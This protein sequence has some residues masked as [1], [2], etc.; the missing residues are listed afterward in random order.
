MKLIIGMHFLFSPLTLS[1]LCLFA[2]FFP[3]FCSFLALFC[4]FPFSNE[5]RQHNKQQMRRD[6][7]YFMCLR[8]I[9][10]NCSLFMWKIC[11]IWILHFLSWNSNQKYKNNVTELKSVSFIIINIYSFNCNDKQIEAFVIFFW[12]SYYDCVVFQSQMSIYILLTLTIWSAIFFFTL[13]FLFVHSKM[14]FS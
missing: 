6:F 7:E 13:I 1:E 2:L 5:I 3:Q 11:V 9:F 12:D 14:Q 4:F 10:N 8:N